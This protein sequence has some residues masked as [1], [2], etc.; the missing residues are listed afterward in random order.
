MTLTVT[1][2]PKEQRFEARLDGELAGFAR[3]IRTHDLIAFVHT[4]V[5]PAFE[6]QGVGS[7]MA[8]TALD[9]ARADGL[10][11]LAACPFISGWMARHPEYLTLAY[12]NRSRVTD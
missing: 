11:V 5:D 3:Y 7:A 12:T 2:V 4:E 8:R 6:G 10:E 1:D 9:S